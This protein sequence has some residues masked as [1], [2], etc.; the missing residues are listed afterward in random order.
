MAEAHRTK[1]SCRYCTH[2]LESFLRNE[3]DFLDGII[4]VDLDDDVRTMWDVLDFYKKAPFIYLMHYPHKTSEGAT[5]FWLREIEELRKKIEEISGVKIT[6]EKLLESIKVYNKTRA[7]IARLYEF[8]KRPQPPLTGTEL[9]AITSTAAVM[10]KE[11]FNN[12]LEELMPYIES[13]KTQQKKD[14]LRILVSGDFLDDVRYIKVVEDSG[15]IVAMDDLDTGSRY[16]FGTVNETM[17]NPEYS[18][19]LY[20]IN[21]PGTNPHMYEWDKQAE[22][23]IKWISEY[24]IDGVVELPTMYSFPRE[25]MTPFFR[26]KLEEKNIPFISLRREYG[27]SN[28]GQLST[29]IGAFFE[30]I[31]GK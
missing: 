16:L 23:V 30:M 22:N 6:D 29:R 17:Y 12:L 20:Y 27:F 10:P 15:C 7:L 14:A 28:V 11:E 18:L 5:R 3:I 1:I 26:M 4:A 8:R 21:R 25:F 13:R 24:K 9:L 19:A 31:K 2:V